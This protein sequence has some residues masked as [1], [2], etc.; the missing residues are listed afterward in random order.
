M[1][2]T[3]HSSTPVAARVR[4]RRGQAA[5][6]LVEIAIALGVIAFALVG[7]LGV[8]PAG[9]RVQ[10]DNREDTIIN[11]D[12]KIL[13]E[14]IRS[15]SRGFDDLTNYV[16]WIGVTNRPR[17]I[18]FLAASARADAKLRADSKMTL[19]NGETIIGLL[20]TPKFF[21]D[22]VTGELL[23]R[24]RGSNT[25]AARIRAMSGSALSRD[26]SLKDI[27]FSYL[28][29]VELVPYQSFIGTPTP[30]APG[31]DILPNSVA[32]QTQPNFYDLRLTIRWPVTEVGKDRTLQVGN[33]RKTFRT[34]V[35]GSVSSNDFLFFVQPNIFYQ[36][37][38]KRP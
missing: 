12:G 19:T 8:L 18:G 16:E 20:S 6:S 17:N 29:S 36:T 38:T 11:Q 21:I 35:S 3:F 13:L 15:G 33:N 31:I 24:Q 4:A 1:R 37:L 10:K 22:P 30:T 25:V 27:T 28:A 26:L 7:I 9:V 5:F 23:N 34:L 14:A 2:T 32:L